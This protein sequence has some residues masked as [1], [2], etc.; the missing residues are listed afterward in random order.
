MLRLACPSGTAARAL[1]A[2]AACSPPACAV[3]GVYRLVPCVLPGR[4]RPLASHGRADGRG[5]STG[6]PL[7]GLVCWVVAA[8]SPP[9]GE[10]LPGAGVETEEGLLELRSRPIFGEEGLLGTR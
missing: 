9:A 10:G 1:R 3:S 7:A 8:T 5:A 6:W 2:R 4:A